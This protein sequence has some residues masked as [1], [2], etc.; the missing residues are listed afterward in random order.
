M[1]K[2]RGPAGGGC[3]QEARWSCGIQSVRK[4]RPRLRPRREPDRRLQ[5]R[6][7][8]PEGAG[9]PSKLRLFPHPVNNVGASA[10]A[11]A[12]RQKRRSTSGALAPTLLLRELVKEIPGIPV[13][14]LRL[15]RDFITHSQIHSRAFDRCVEVKGLAHVV[16]GLMVTLDLP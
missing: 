2:G 13:W 6:L 4:R 1:P 12:Q 9:P 14:T 11:R 8:V 5:A 10:L 16:A 15:L 3:G 7:R